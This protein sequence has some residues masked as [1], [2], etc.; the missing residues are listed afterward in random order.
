MK[1]DTV[2]LLVKKLKKKK[3]KYTGLKKIIFPKFELN[4]VKPYRLD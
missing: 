1:P 4:Y 2:K 3:E